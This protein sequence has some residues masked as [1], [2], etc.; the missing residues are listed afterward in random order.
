MTTPQEIDY[1]LKLLNKAVEEIPKRS[2]EYAKW[3]REYRVLLRQQ[4][5]QER[6]NGTPVTIAYDIARGEEQVANAKEQEIISKGML[7]SCYEAINVYKLETKVLTNYFD[8]EYN[9]G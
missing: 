2:K 3:Y 5:M 9:N 8:K 7:D 1:K 4:L 6:L